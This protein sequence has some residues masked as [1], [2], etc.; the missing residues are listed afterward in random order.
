MEADDESALLFRSETQR[1][2]SCVT[3]IGSHPIAFEVMSKRRNGYP[4][5]RHVKR[6]LRV[7]HGDKEF[8]REAGP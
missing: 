1:R 4:S 5:E 8:I 7:V 6:G 2:V 3:T